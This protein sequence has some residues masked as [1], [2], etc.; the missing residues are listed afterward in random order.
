MRCSTKGP[1]YINSAVRTS[2]YVEPGRVNPPSSS[3]PAQ[4]KVPASTWFATRATTTLLTLRLHMF[5][6]IPS[7]FL[8]LKCGSGS[9]AY[10][11][12]LQR[13]DWIS[14]HCSFLDW[15]RRCSECCYEEFDRFFPD[16]LCRIFFQRF[17]SGHCYTPAWGNFTLPR[18]AHCL[19][20]R[21]NVCSC[22]EKPGQ[23]DSHPVLSGV[24]GV[25]IQSD[26]IHW[27]TLRL[28]AKQT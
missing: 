21:L 10:S 8:E 12:P 2:R 25:F 11:K 15:F 26:L 9:L 28:G 7:A 27:I 20:C 16:G 5:A 3:R 6:S 24:C 17:L 13:L 22:L 18:P 4:T 14:F 1:T 23:H 19:G